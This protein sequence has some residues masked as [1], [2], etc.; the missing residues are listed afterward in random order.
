MV[1]V[2]DQRGCPCSICA[3]YQDSWPTR[4][5][6]GGD[7]R[8]TLRFHVFHVLLDNWPAPAFGS[9]RQIQHVVAVTNKVIDVVDA[10]GEPPSGDHG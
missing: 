1:A 6:S 2:T 5:E 4:R 8:E 10:H 7:L 3:E 9:D